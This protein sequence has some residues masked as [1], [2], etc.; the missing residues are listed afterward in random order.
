MDA[1]K[2]ERCFSMSMQDKTQEKNPTQKNHY[3]TDKQVSDL[4]GIA[5]QTLRN[6][7]HFGKGPPY[8][9]LEKS[10]R[11]RESDVIE[12][13]DSRIVTPGGSDGARHE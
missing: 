7:R 3:L 10:V 9:K 13:M 8:V 12:F 5:L 6:Y 11:Y 1:E 4:T 2:Q